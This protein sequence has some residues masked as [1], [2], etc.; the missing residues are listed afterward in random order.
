MKKLKYCPYGKCHVF[1][2]KAYIDGSGF[3]IYEYHLISYQSKVLIYRPNTNQLIIDNEEITAHAD[4]SATTRTHVAAF[5]KEYVP[6]ITYSDI[7]KALGKG[8][9]VINW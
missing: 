8:E 5:L 3:P 7:K 2:K 6:H 1:V 9:C 4:Y